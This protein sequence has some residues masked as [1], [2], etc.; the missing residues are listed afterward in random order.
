[1]KRTQGAVTG[2][3]ESE[4]QEEDGG[5]DRGKVGNVGGFSDMHCRDGKEHKH[6]HP[7]DTHSVDDDAKTNA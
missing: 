7:D 6:F 5:D 1:M 4:R 3:S 2:F